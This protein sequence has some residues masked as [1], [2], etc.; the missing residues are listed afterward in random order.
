MI[1]LETD[2]NDAICQRARVEAL[3]ELLEV[4]E[5]VVQ[6]HSDR[7]EA[8]MEELREY[9]DRLEA[10]QSELR[11]QQ[12]A[13]SRLERLAT[14]DGLT[15]LTNH[16]T[17]QEQLGEAFD[18]S[19]HSSVCLSLVMLDVDYFKQYNDAFGHP[20]G[21]LVLKRVADIMKAQ[22]RKIDTA[23]RYGG[24][25]F[26]LLLPKADASQAMTIAEQLRAAIE[27]A[28]W[29]ERTITVSVG[30]ATLTPEIATASTLLEH[31]DAAL[32]S[33]KQQGRNRV[34][35]HHDVLST[36]AAPV[37][38]HMMDHSGLMQKILHAH[39]DSLA[40]MKDYVMNALTQGYVAII[41]SWSQALELRHVETE[42]HGL[43]VAEKMARLAR[44]VGM[45]E[46][47]VLYA[48]WGA[49][50]H[51]IGKTNVPDS[52]LLKRDRL[53]EEEWAIIRRHPAT[54]YQMLSPVFFLRPALDIPH[55]CNEKWD[56]TGYPRGLR[57]EEIPV[58]ARLFAVI[59][60][61]EALSS[62]RPY[63]AAWPQSKVVAHIRALSGSHF[64]PR[65]VNAFFST[66]ADTIY[67][68]N[69]FREAA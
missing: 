52:I 69:A 5:S 12:E 41:T 10:Q 29:I 28:P 53:T 14:T 59:H 50:L 51:D 55:C 2:A 23:A 26:A 35:H 8:A 20:K 11:A 32:Y 67:P 64:D 43:R 15:K 56:G 1:S 45:N 57:G 18:R 46:E 47:E 40:S 62:E 4:Q 25:E 42:G 6:A 63:R 54:A 21:D 66:F 58:S 7:L 17:F 34:T 48:R 44:A 3:E 39:Q 33:S 22:V 36:D 27:N 9:A 49:L 68:E 24:E 13:N 65:A 31:A 19:L 37:M 60:V 61:W 38:D 30:V 16:R